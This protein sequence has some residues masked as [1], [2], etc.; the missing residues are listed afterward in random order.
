M[1]AVEIIL[2]ELADSVIEGKQGRVDKVDEA[3]PQQ[4]ARRRSARATFRAEDGA[5]AAATG[6]EAPAAEAGSGAAEAVPVAVPAEA[7]AVPEAQ[8]V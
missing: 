6:A 7:V 1:R 8:P 5:P 4:G 2:H 3:S